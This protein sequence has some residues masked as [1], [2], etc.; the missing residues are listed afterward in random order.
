MISAVDAY[1]PQNDFGC[2][3]FVGNVRQWTSTLWGEKHVT[4]DLQYK[5]PWK[6]DRRNDLNANSLI[7]RVLRGCTFTSD[8]R[9]ARCSVRSGQL[10]SDTGFSN[11]GIGFRV[12]MVLDNLRSK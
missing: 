7:R 5:Y 9:K 4:P 6:D 3:D 11:T 8:S 10:P 12:A 2:F 1:P